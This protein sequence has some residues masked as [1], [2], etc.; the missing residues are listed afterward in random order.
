[1]YAQ[2]YADRVR[3]I[4]ISGVWL[5]EQGSIDWSFQGTSGVANL[6]PDVLE[7]REA[8]FQR[9][10]T[11]A[12]DA[13]RVLSDLLETGDLEEQK[14]IAAGVMNWE[15]NLFSPNSPISFMRPEDVD[16]NALTYVKIFL[17]YEKNDF[18]IQDDQILNNVDT[19]KDV[20]CVMVHGRY[21]VVCPMKYPHQLKNAM[22][23][24]ELFIASESGH[25]LSV[26]GEEIR[27]IS[28]LRFLEQNV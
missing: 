20:P 17:H 19:I 8:F 2:A 18:F 11:N 26:E 6:V 1:M 5:A 9:Y 14:A 15:L 12:K 21:D 10:N 23:K 3:G 27:R 24:A 4:L 28:Y 7:K 13:P 22:N 25:K 16:E